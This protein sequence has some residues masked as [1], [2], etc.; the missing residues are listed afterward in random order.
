MKKALLSISAMLVLLAPLAA[1]SIEVISPNGGEAWLQGDLKAIA[2]KKTNVN[3]SMRIVLLRAGDNSKFGVIIENLAGSCSNCSLDW[4]VGHT[5]DGD[6]PPGQYKIR[7][8]TTDGTIKDVSN[9]AFTILVN[10]S[11]PTVK[12][13][14]P[15]GGERWQKGIL[16]YIKWMAMNLPPSIEYLNYELWQNGQKMGDI[17]RFYLSKKG[18]YSGYSQLNWHVGVLTT[19]EAGP[20]TGYKVRVAAGGNSQTMPA[21]LIM[22]ESDGVFEILSPIIADAAAIIVKKPEEGSVF[23]YDASNGV[24]FRIE[25]TQARHENDEYVLT[26]CDGKGKRIRELFGCPEAQHCDCRL[27]AF[28]TPAGTYR[29][30]VVNINGTSSGLSGEFRLRFKGDM[31][32]VHR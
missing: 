16:R 31:D 28:N 13:L 26:L 9:A 30:K 7:V 15:N 8:I 12:M 5:L 32:A 29:I 4:T 21:K 23:T 27:Y 20:G 2:F 17:G 24:S 18:I 22:D 25:W 6:A 10:N 19:A 14:D 3:Q 1:A 11:P